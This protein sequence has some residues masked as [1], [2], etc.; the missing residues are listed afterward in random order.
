MP[1]F[2]QRLCRRRQVICIGLPQRRYGGG[3]RKFSRRYD[4]WRRTRHRR[5]RVEGDGG[6][7]ATAGVDSDDGA[8]DIRRRAG[9]GGFR[10]IPIGKKQQRQQETT[11]EQDIS[12][13]RHRLL[14]AGLQAG[15]IVRR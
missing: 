3:S 15:P 10:E 8:V 4:L 14:T 12:D 7:P 13:E 9:F 5:T 11:R 6:G 2:L 1:W